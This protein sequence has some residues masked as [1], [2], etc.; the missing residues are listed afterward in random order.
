MYTC[1]LASIIIV[2]IVLVLLSMCSESYTN[3]TANNNLLLDPYYSLAPF[4]KPVSEQQCHPEPYYG[5]INYGQEVAGYCAGY[6]RPI[7]Q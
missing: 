3:V 4:N 2:L 5:K 7:D 6:K 1:L